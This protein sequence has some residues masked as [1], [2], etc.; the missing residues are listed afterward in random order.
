MKLEYSRSFIKQMKKAPKNIQKAVR[1][2]LGI[3]VSDKFHPLLNKH[4]L[5]GNYRSFRS[6]NI[7]GDW[8]AVYRET[9]MGTAYFEALGTHSQLYK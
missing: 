2:R 7:S 1:G 4:A 5:Q 6:I 8:R 3:F 9:D